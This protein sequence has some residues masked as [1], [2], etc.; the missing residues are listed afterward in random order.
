MKKLLTLFIVV[1]MIF[2]AIPM[3]V[4][5]GDHV[6]TPNA[7][8]IPAAPVADPDNFTVYV[9]SS[10]S[11]DNEGKT[12]DTAVATLT[13]AHS[14]ITDKSTTND[15]N[16]CVLTDINMAAN[17]SF[18]KYQKGTVYIYGQENSGKYPTVKG[19]ATSFVTLGANTVFYNINF[20]CGTTN[21][22]VLSAAF[23]KL[24]IGENFTAGTICYITGA[25]WY[26]ANSSAG[27][28]DFG[29]DNTPKNSAVINIYSGS[30]TDVFA[31][32]RNAINTSTTITN[33]NVPCEVNVY[34]ED[35][36]I[37]NLYD[38]TA[39]KGYDMIRNTITLNVFAGEV[40]NLISNARYT[41]GTGDA[42]TTIRNTVLY[43]SNG[44]ITNFTRNGLKGEHK[45]F[46]NGEAKYCGIQTGTYEGKNAVRFV[47]T[48]DSL[49]YDAVGL[50]IITGEGYDFTTS[51]KTVYTTI[52]GA[53]NSNDYEYTTDD[54]GGEGIFAVVIKGIP[55][56][57]VTFDVRPFYTKD[58]VDYYG[59]RYTVTVIDGAFVS[60]VIN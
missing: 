29:E 46:T 23:H 50:Q 19:S 11:D 8:T 26:T 38:V 13:K 9:S 42:A 15:A 2:S 55:S 10:G 5:A 40:T 58:G 43:Y 25:V 35:V 22:T 18:S 27:N 53:D 39:N 3:T 47:G 37:D 34:G 56:G 51:C 17:T 31:T 60:S 52:L 16:I 32:Y 41:D 48:V 20:D 24:T 7:S 28:I 30:F 44:T 57:T 14:L 33:I 49:N 4:S 45:L 59:L 36:T 1:C 21:K 54:L 6:E 12:K